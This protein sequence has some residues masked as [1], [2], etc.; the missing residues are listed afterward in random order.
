MNGTVSLGTFVAIQLGS[1]LEACIASRKLKE[2]R[3]DNSI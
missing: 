3:L 1:N 2:Y